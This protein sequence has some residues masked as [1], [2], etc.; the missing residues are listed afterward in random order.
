MKIKNKIK[1]IHELESI[2]HRVIDTKEVWIIIFCVTWLIVISSHPIIL[3]V[4]VI[5]QTSLVSITLWII[6]S[7]SWI[8]FILFLIFIGGLMVLFVYIIS[9]AS[10][11]IFNIFNSTSII[12]IIIPSLLSLTLY[13]T[14][15]NH[16]I[17]T[18]SSLNFTHQFNKIYTITPRLII[19]FTIAY[20]LI[21]LIVAVKI[22]NLK[23]APIKNI[24]F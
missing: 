15:K 9:L 24:F 7:N 21:T 18:E 17:N 3:L 20:L 1:E 5:I 16:H 19:L 12:I 11:E 2:I 10:N 22:S 13:L 23:E 8:S 14:L 4:T 6:L